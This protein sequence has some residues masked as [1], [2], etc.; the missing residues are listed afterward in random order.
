[1]NKE[2]SLDNPAE[3]AGDE[4]H[5]ES[6][7]TETISPPIALAAAKSKIGGQVYKMPPPVIPKDNDDDDDE[8]QAEN[9]PPVLTEPLPT[10]LKSAFALVEKVSAM[11]ERNKA[12]KR[13]KYRLLYAVKLN[14]KKLQQGLPGVTFNSED[15]AKEKARHIADI[16]LTRQE[17]LT[18]LNR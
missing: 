5:T 15:I 18:R 4:V 10:D 8:T 14:C 13:A 16:E 9:E 6:A 2:I 7:H 11:P 1:M 3:S 17:I 12:E